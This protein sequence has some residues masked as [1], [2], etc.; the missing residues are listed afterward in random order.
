[1]L[2][3]C[4][5]VGGI[6]AADL[7]AREL[8]GVPMSVD[9]SALDMSTF[10]PDVCFA[11]SPAAKSLAA[12]LNDDTARGGRGAAENAVVVVPSGGSAIVMLHR[13]AGVDGKLPPPPPREVMLVRSNVGGV[14]GGSHDDTAGSSSFFRSPHGN[15][16][17]AQPLQAVFR[18]VPRPE[19]MM[20]V[21]ESVLQAAFGRARDSLVILDSENRIVLATS[22]FC[23]LVR[24]HGTALEGRHISAVLG[25]PTAAVVATAGTAAAATAS[26][27]TR[28]GGG[29]GGRSPQQAVRRAAIAK[30]WP[31]PA[32]RHVCTVVDHHE[33]DPSAPP[34]NVTVTPFFANGVEHTM[35]LVSDSASGGSNLADADADAR[36]ASTLSVAPSRDRT[37]SWGSTSVQVQQPRRLSNMSQASSF[38]AMGGGILGPIQE[39]LDDAA[40]DG[41]SEEPSENLLD[42]LDHESADLDGKDAVQAL[43]ASRN[44]S[45][46]TLTKESLARHAAVEHHTE[47]PQQHPGGGLDESISTTSLTAASRAGRARRSKTHGD[48][49][50]ILTCD[51]DERITSHNSAAAE[52]L[53]YLADGGDM[54]AL[55]GAVLSS[56]F[57]GPKGSGVRIVKPRSL[58]QLRQSAEVSVEFPVTARDG[59]SLKCFVRP[60]DGELFAYVFSFD[61]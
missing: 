46:L 17:M 57:S 61:G 6:I 60:I 12:T 2:C 32:G 27:S 9:I 30:V 58:A 40:E 39:E 16:V 38:A 26:A 21:G 23:A 19:Q 11:S 7:A 48:V 34:I 36:R 4:D 50:A 56:I 53:S 29:D 8:L 37:R 20:A 47:S 18:I 41:S 54:S 33:A 43:M 31:L 55:H 15:A 44:N 35:L 28:D 51:V 3:R 14:D 25:I 52:Q 49:R 59:T 45:S 42:Q 24:S 22:P 13:A 1:V 5:A 10:F